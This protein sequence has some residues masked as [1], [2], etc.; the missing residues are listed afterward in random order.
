[1]DF[2]GVQ[3]QSY[4]TKMLL[5]VVFDKRAFVKFMI[6]NNFQQN[7][8]EKYSKIPKIPIKNARTKSLETSAKFL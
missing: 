7:I 8:D 3:D 2:F 4:D 5:K 1:M 6:S